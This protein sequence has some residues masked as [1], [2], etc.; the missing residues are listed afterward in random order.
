MVLAASLSVPASAVAAAPVAGAQP[1][2]TREDVPTTV[3]LVGIDGDGDP[4]TFELTTPPLLGTLGELGARDCDGNV[5]QT[6]MVD[7]QYTPSPDVHGLD[8]FGFSV[9][10]GAATVTATANV[11]VTSVND[12]PT[13]T[14]GADQV[15]LEDAGPRSIPGWATAI[16]AGPSNEAGQA[17]SLVG[18]PQIPTCSARSRRSPPSGQLTF[19]PAPNA[20][21]SNQL[22]ATLHDS[23]GPAMAVWTCVTC[24]QSFTIQITAVNDPPQAVDDTISVDEDSGVTVLDLLAND[25]DSSGCR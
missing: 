25:E 4:T 20:N 3:T 11:A 24:P 10:D 22:R 9:S 1:A 23:G 14:A 15:V 5:P 21:G 6:C 17:V 16:S 7:V 18:W 19:T 8:G 12:A 2:T 13:F